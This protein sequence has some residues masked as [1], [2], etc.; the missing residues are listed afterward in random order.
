MPL[1][2]IEQKIKINKLKDRNPLVIVN[3]LYG[4]GVKP[5]KKMITHPYFEN[6]SCK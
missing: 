1:D 3:I 6:F 4:M 5:A 2:K